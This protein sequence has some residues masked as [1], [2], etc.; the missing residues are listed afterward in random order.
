MITDAELIRVN[1][2]LNIGCIKNKY[3]LKNVVVTLTS[4]GLPYKIP[5]FHLYFELSN[6]D[7]IEIKISESPGSIII[8]LMEGLFP[9]IMINPSTIN[10]TYICYNSVGDIISSL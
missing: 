3:N 9:Y 8:D 7:I 5:Q 4:V 1:K 10:F 6:F 2:I